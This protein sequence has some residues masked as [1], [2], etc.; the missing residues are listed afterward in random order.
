[1]HED[2]K[3]EP[4][5]LKQALNCGYNKKWQEAMKEELD[6]LIKN[7]TWTVVDLPAGRK[8]VGCKWVYKLKLDENGNISKYKARLVAQ[9]F[10]QIHGEDC[11]EVFSPVCKSASF[12]LLLS[13][14]CVKNYIVHQ[15][16]VKSAFLNGTLKETIYM[17]QPPG[18]TIGNKVFKLEKSLYGLKQSANVWN[19]A[20][21]DHLVDKMKFKQRS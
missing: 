14:A 4:K 7:K 5:T 1:M 15:I 9:G 10:T 19:E 13:E 6:T 12:R 8:A 3:Y 20:L 2:E 18:Y 11:D 21:R 17:R 16:D